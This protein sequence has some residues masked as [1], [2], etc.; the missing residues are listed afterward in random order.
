MRKLKLSLVAVLV[1]VVVGVLVALL[2]GFFAHGF[3]VELWWFSALG[4]E[5]LFWYRLFHDYGLYLGSILFFFLIF[6]LNFRLGAKYLGAKHPLLRETGI[7]SADA[8]QDP[9]RYRK[10]YRRVQ[11]ASVA[12]YLP[13][14]LVLAVVLSL[15]MIGEGE[16][17]LLAL[18]AED[19]GIADPLYGRDIS[20]YLFLLPVQLVFFRALGLGLA[21]LLLGLTLLYWLEARTLQREDK[22]LHRG[23][24]IHLHVVTLLL[25]AVAAGYF[26]LEARLLLYTDSHMPVFYGPGYVERQFILPM[27][28]SSM[29]LLFAAGL[30]FVYYVDTRKG[31]RAVAAMTVLFLVSLGIRHF[32]YTTDVLQEY[33]VQPNEA[34]LE[35]PY[36]ANNIEATLSA[37]DLVDVET[38]EYPIKE[39]PWDLAPP[40]MRLN[41]ESIPIWNEDGLLPLYRELQSIRSY[42]SFDSVDVGR[43]SV[44]GAYRQVFLAVREINLDGLPS[45]ANSWVNRWLKYTHGYGAVMTTAAQKQA[46]PLDF[47]VQGIPPSSDFGLSIE[48]PAIY[49]GAGKYYPAIAPNDSRELDYSVGDI[50]QLSDYQGE[51]GIRLSSELREFVLALYFREK[52]IILTDQTNGQSRLLFRRNIVD[53][54][55]ELTPFLL[56][57]PN[58]YAVITPKRIYWIQDA[59]TH[60]SWYPNSRPY[61]GRF[62]PFGEEFNYIRNSVKIVVDAY[63]GSVDYY[64]S[65]EAD[66]IIGAYS[67]IHPE[68]FRPI[69]EMPSAIRQ[70]ARYPK[71][72]FDIQ[73]DI[74]GRYHQRDPGRY[75][76]EEDF[77]EFAVAPGRENLQVL[78]SNYVTLNL[79]DRDR[80]EYSLSLPMTPSGKRNMRTLAVAGSDGDNYGRIITY[81]FPAGTLVYGPGQVDSIINQDPVITRQLGRWNL[82][83]SKVYRGRMVIMPIGGAITYIQGVFIEAETPARLPELAR[84]I[85][86]RGQ[87]VAMERSIEEAFEAVNDLIESNSAPPA[88]EQ[89]PPTE[90]P[91]VTT[92]EEGAE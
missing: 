39:A 75:Y 2:L 18:F 1:A 59:Y 49:Y 47:L 55:T 70:H 82:T 17:V 44:Q 32:P 33:L 54:I 81:T 50:T 24:R 31:V 38:R 35:A 63:D 40:D 61:D 41:I 30:A 6:F 72:L 26:L 27:V 48:E 53:R 20:Y 34:S 37:Y 15:P 68:I 25:L 10:K 28:L 69:S 45:N 67:R 43:Y 36:I 78:T 85:V 90:T 13:L 8:A 71:T 65:D 64:V 57:D 62:N 9:Q 88:Q 16:K 5:G 12:F 3:L 58:P 73:M 7:G 80:W 21:G 92:G 42:Y 14:S 89:P 4:Y 23:G 51:G 83:G 56:L 46:G 11:K 52:N 79:I 91:E 60:S 87:M 29:A 66:P 22:R 77:W 74:Y 19:A 76:N 86:S 84:I